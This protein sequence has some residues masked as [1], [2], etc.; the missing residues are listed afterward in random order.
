[1]IQ[2]NR[3]ALRRKQCSG[4]SLLEMVI[5]TG[6]LLAS[7]AMLAQLAS[8]GRRHLASAAEKAI[9][10]RLCQNQ[11]A[12]LMAGVDPIEPEDG[13]PLPEDL[14]WD[15][16]VTVSELPAAELSQ[17]EVG[18]RRSESGATPVPADDG[19][20]FTLVRWIP[21]RLVAP[22]AHDS[23]GP[24]RNDANQLESFSENR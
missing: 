3:H 5:A 13:A 14:D 18:V 9:A 20:W 21:N 11:L 7:V 23:A 17:L 2:L 16:R 6:I 4:F 1:M 24:Q 22:Q 12:R 19:Q 10:M 8:V 15:F